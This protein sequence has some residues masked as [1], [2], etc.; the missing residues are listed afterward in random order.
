MN[1]KFLLAGLAGFL[2]CNSISGCGG[3]SE[4][5]SSQPL[6]A[7]ITEKYSLHTV[8]SAMT[9]SLTL[10]Q[11][12][13]GADWELKET[14]CQSAG[15]DLTPFAGQNVAVVRYNLTDKYSDDSLSLVILAQDQTCLCSYIAATN[16]L[17]GIIAVNDP[18]INVTTSSHNYNTLQYSLTSLGVVD[19]GKNIPVTLSIKNTASA[20][21]DVPLGVPEVRAQVTKSDSEV[22][23][24]DFGVASPAVLHQFSLPAGEIKA[25]DFIWNQKDNAGNQVAPG[26][27]TIKATFASITEQVDTLIK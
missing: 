6:V 16:L 17:P 11:Q 25:Y 19:A 8:G 18:H 14:V 13:T 4:S 21:F 2:L 26:N 24:S 10:P 12:F 7:T 15:Y 9:V 23:S 1:M 5:P 22:W 20:S 3:S 27:Y